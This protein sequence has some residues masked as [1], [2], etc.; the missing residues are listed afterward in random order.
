MSE[1]DSLKILSQT[2][3]N[4]MIPYNCHSGTFPEVEAEREVVLNS[5]LVLIISNREIFAR[6]KGT[7]V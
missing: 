2:K 5:M 7:Y 4:V 3:I 1:V 6:N